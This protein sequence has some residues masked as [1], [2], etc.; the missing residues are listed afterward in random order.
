[1]LNMKAIPCIKADMVIN[2]VT[3]AY[4]K[5]S[6]SRQGKLGRSSAGRSRS[7]YGNPRVCE[8]GKDARHQNTNTGM[9]VPYDVTM[10]ITNEQT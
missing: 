9:R 4:R 1:M 10:E 6:R 5:C 3:S 7:N 2:Q 8:L